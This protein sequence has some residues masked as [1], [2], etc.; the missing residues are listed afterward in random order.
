MVPAKDINHIDRVLD[1][2]IT[3]KKG[4]IPLKKIAKVIHKFEPTLIT[5][6]ALEFTVEVYGNREKMA[7]SHI[8]SDFE[9]Q[10]KAVKLPPNVELEQTGDIKQFKESAKRMIGAIITAVFLI[11]LTLVVMF[12]DIKISLMILFSISTHNNWSILDM[13]TV[14]YISQ[15][16]Q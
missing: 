9:N 7:I 11:F 14:H 3:T 10:L 12:G 5:R 16:L 4:K 8:M 2:L 15:C 1:T 13:L 6:E